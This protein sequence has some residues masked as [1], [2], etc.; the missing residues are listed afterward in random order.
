MAVIFIG[1]GAFGTMYGITYKVAY[2]DQKHTFEIAPYAINA[3][4]DRVSE[5]HLVQF[6]TQ[7][8]K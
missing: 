1:I 3:G 6:W 2:Y 5:V 4:G 7:E 8:K